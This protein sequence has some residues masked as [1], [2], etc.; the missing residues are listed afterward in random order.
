M[1]PGLKTVIELQQL[2]AQIAEF[3]AQ[4]ELLPQ[5]VQ[6]LETQLH[7]FIH[8]H[9]ERKQRLAKNQKERK[10]SE[11]EI[12]TIRARITKHKDQLY[13]VKTNEQYKAMLKEIE[14]EEAKVRAFEDRILEKMLE[15]EDLE[16]H[17][18]DA[19]ARLDS[20]KARVAAEVQKLQALRQEDVEKRNELQVR[21]DADAA[22]IEPQLLSLY[23]R[24]RRGKRGLAVAEVRDGM[25]TA[26]NVMLRPQLFNEIRAN[27]SVVTCEQ[28]GRILHFTE[29]PTDAP[30][31]A[32]DQLASS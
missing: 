21:R 29:P 16:E 30:E 32:G 13:E 26:C 24:L 23:E 5:E 4:I 20:E 8:A 2:D 1:H 11:A 14:G 10:E 28:C 31:A 18:R 22:S 17:I 12:Q 9:E 19:A 25:C 15:A 7:E 3:S 27:E 6:S